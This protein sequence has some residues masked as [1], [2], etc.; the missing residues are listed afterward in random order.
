MI[1]LDH[2]YFGCTKDAY[3]TIAAE[4]KDKPFSK[5]QHVVTPDESWNGLYV[6]MRDGTYFEFLK[7]RRANNFG[8][9]FYT[10]TPAEEGVPKVVL[11]HPALHWNKGE[12]LTSDGRFWF[13]WYSLNEYRNLDLPFN[14][15]TMQYSAEYLVRKNKS[16]EKLAKSP[17]ERIHK[18]HLEA[19]S[20]LK[21]DFVKNSHFFG[22]KIFH[23]EDSSLIYIEGIK[24]VILWQNTD[25]SGLKLTDFDFGNSNQTPS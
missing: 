19:S 9:A 10:V 4:F 20:S 7:E 25:T 14:F 3:G 5:E 13:N 18:I 1:F 11:E 8:I 24:I 22:D 15:W 6:S 16:L 2:L 21:S 17:Y 23:G 12:R